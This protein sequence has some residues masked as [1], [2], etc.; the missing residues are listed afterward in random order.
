MDSF[1]FRKRKVGI[2]RAACR[3]ESKGW[4]LEKNGHRLII[5]TAVCGPA[6]SEL[7][8]GSIEKGWNGKTRFDFM[9]KVKLK[10]IYAKNAIT[11]KALD[12]YSS[13]N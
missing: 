13:C 5:D 9:L 7:I 2:V 3:V 1:V 4:A 10:Y 11:L 8:A 12:M 6:R